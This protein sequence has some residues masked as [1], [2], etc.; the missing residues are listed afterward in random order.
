MKFCLLATS[1]RKTSF[2]IVNWS[3]NVWWQTGPDS[4]RQNGFLWCSRH[5]C[6]VKESR[7]VATQLETEYR[8]S[9]VTGI[10]IGCDNEALELELWVVVYRLSINAH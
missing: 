1:E 6:V 2:D 9:V 7:L 3:G 5:E 8:L 4:V 10:G